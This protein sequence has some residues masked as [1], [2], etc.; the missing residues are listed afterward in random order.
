MP[1]KHLV[2][3]LCA[4]CTTYQ[5][6]PSDSRESTRSSLEIGDAPS[7]VGQPLY[8][9]SL[10]EARS[11]TLGPADLI[12]ND[13]LNEI[14]DVIVDGRY[15]TA[16]DFY[17][18]ADFKLVSGAGS[19]SDGAWRFTRVPATV[20]VGV[21]IPG[22]ITR[23]SLEFFLGAYNRG[24]AGTLVFK[25]R[26]RSITT[27]GQPFDIGV[28]TIRCCGD[29]W[30]GAGTVFGNPARGGGPPDSGIGLPYKPPV[31]TE[32]WVEVTVDNVAN[33]LGGIYIEHRN[34]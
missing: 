14:Q 25:L 28:R 7:D 31:G 19:F 2:L 33:Q 11:I 18:A 17:P 8:K 4:S 20:V 10:P 1:A 5:Q 24:N 21:V 29:V 16:A 6:Y 34:V 15:S 27:G 30:T 3:A 26:A 23:P 22:G 13:L 32:V 12:P 9:P